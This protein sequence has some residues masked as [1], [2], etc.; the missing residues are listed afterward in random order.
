M[1]LRRK[2]GIDS[3]Y[4]PPPVT[5]AMVERRLLRLEKDLGERRMQQLEAD[6]RALQQ[7]V[8]QLER[9]QHGHCLG[10]GDTTGHYSQTHCGREDCS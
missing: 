8:E 7:R 4:E 9:G 6:Y 3:F 1:R 2:T 5:M 10:C